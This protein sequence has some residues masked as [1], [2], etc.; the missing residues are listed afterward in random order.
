[1][2]RKTVVL[3]AL[4]LLHQN[5]SAQD[6]VS[7]DG[8]VVGHDINVNP[9][10]P[11]ALRAILGERRFD[12][13]YSP[14]TSRQAPKA[15]RIRRFDSKAVAKRIGPLLQTVQHQEEPFNNLCPY[16]RNASGHLSQERC[17]AGCVATSIEQI[18]AYYKYPEALVDTLLGWSTDN[19]TIDDLLPGTRFD[20]NNHLNDYRN[21]YTDEEAQAVALPMLAAGMAVK[22]RYGTGSSGANTYLAVEPL[23]RAFGYGMARW[24]D[25]LLYSPKQWHE[26]LQ[27]ELEQGRPVAYVGHNMEM[28]GHAFNIDGVDEQGFY[29]INWAYGGAY[30]GWFDLDWLCPWENYD[31]IQNSIAYGF[32]CNQGAL[33]M[34]P[35]ADAHPLDGD[36]L[37]IDNLG[38]E[39]TGFNM[40]RQPDTQGYTPTDFTFTNHGTADVTY[41]YEIFTNLPT[42]TAFFEQADYIGISAVNVPAGGTTTQRMFLMFHQAGERTLSISHDD[43]TIPFS[44]PVSVAVGEEASLSWD[45]L[46]MEIEE[47]DDMQAGSTLT[48]HFTVDVANHSTGIYGSSIILYCLYP[49]GHEDEDLRHFA[50]IDLPPGTS[51]TF[52]ASFSHLQP[53]TRYH[54][55]LR[56]PWTIRKE[57]EFDTPVATSISSPLIVNHSSNGFDV[58]GRPWQRTRQGLMIKDGQKWLKR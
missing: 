54:F 37:D 6:F 43:I 27:H 29:H 38:I 19:Y 26:L 21:G 3:L 41:T 10:M 17:L 30:D 2:A 8:I 56:S 58:L 35:S 44:T 22:M 55:I 40:L 31:I 34:H 28:K 33:L 11:E 51:Q 50:I 53:A 15:Q 9:Q 36:S 4:C 16:Y 47:P 45:N 32:F 18:L 5:A 20:W 25:R 23:K 7:C 12:S 39:V 48:A 42:D 1:M 49:D 13:S 14:S 57:L 52:S 24:H 46:K